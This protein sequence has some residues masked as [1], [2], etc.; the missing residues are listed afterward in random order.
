MNEVNNIVV[1]GRRWFSRTHGNTY[2]TATILING[3]F[4]TK[5]GPSYGYDSYYVQAADDWLE[6]NGYMPD[7]EHHQGGSAEPGWRYFR[8]D[9]KIPYS[10]SAVDVARKRDL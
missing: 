6:E 8:D 9:R 2:F 4:A 1:Q 7:R 3:E 10:Y 5:I